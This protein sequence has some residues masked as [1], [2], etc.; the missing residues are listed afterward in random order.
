MKHATPV[1]ALALS[2][3]SLASA[4]SPQA[5]PPAQAPGPRLIVAISVDQMRYDY[6]ERFRPLF[7]GGL[8]T[9]IE[10]GAVFS[11]ARYRHANCETGPGHSV[12][13]SGRNALHSGIVANAWY[14]GALRRVVNVVDDPT[15]RPIGGPGRGASPANFIGFTF[16]DVLKKT[17]PEAR[18][19]GVSLKD[20]SA[21]L[22]AGPRGDA[23][24]WYE[25]ANGRFITSSYYM[26]KA[27]AWLD[28]IND[29][30]I[31]D[32]YASKQWTRLL[33]DEALYL[34]HAGPDAVTNENDQ[35]DNVFPHVIPGTPGSPAFYDGFR[36][37][38]WA[39]DLTLEVAFAAI[40]A[41]DLG[42]DDIPDLLAVG[43]SAN[44]VI[45]HAYGPDSQE[46][47]D[48]QLRLDRNLQKLF[49]AVE[50]KVG[51]G[52]AVF[53]LSAD[54]SVMPLV[55]SLQKQGVAARRLAPNAVQTAVNAALEKRF[56]GVNVKDLVSSYLA[57]DFY[58]NLE[59]IA[60]QG[61][62]RKDVEQTI[63]DALMATGDVA[64]VYTA[65]SFSGEPPSATDDPYFDA[66]QR[67]YFAP[68]SPHVI[69][70]LKEYIYLSGYPG[71]T[72]HGTSYEYDRHVPLVFMGPKV[73]AGHYE[74]D[75]GPEDIAPALG[76]LL[77]VDYPLQDARRV[78]TEMIQR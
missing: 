3:S 37:T 18:S 74:G 55:E 22:M 4:Q 6:L 77:G 66:V 36:K 38:P 28:A 65:A 76:A 72:G 42:S 75:T 51:A 13:L 48:Q 7:T 46:I 35:K 54:H 31:P 52:R 11:N 21:I 56:P 41:H 73:K 19:V 53:V 69:A 49:D 62:K 44:D 2:V 25:Q 68:R 14:D 57:P 30:K 12:I 1:L 70:R 59:F 32:S 20:R 24:Y 34:K 8:K 45:G 47:M 26:Q 29:R 58:L 78:L 17:Y 15:V 67:S 71:G 43:L 27:P 61:L 60:K 5:P 39:D 16:G 40:K 10:K 23:A 9:L 33:P 63:S 50:A 64:K